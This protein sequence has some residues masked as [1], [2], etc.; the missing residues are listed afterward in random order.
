MKKG[1]EGRG[2]GERF[3][4]PSPYFFGTITRSE[5]LLVGKCHIGKEF[6]SHKIGLKHQHGSLET[7]TY[8]VLSPR[9]YDCVRRSPSCPLFWLFCLGNTNMS[10]LWS[11]KNSLLKKQTNNGKI[12]LKNWTSTGFPHVFLWTNAPTPIIGRK[13]ILFWDW[14]P[15][16][17]WHRHLVSSL[18]ALPPSYRR[19]VVAR[20]IKLGTVW[21]ICPWTC[22]QESF[23]RLSSLRTLHLPNV[24]STLRFTRI[25]VCCGSILSLV[26]TL[27][28]FLLITIHY[29]TPKQ[30][31]IKFN[32]EWNW[33][34]TY[35]WESG[36]CGGIFISDYSVHL[37]QSHR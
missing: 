27:V 34:T 16:S 4:S 5:T 30:R 21:D 36:K 25:D 26:F 29:H 6:S 33:T 7:P 9:K 8:F 10:W 24:D 14:W 28:I 3:L 32:P 37:Q 18:E 11:C 17:P 22:Y 15:H 13:D 20:E 23:Q 1:D 31:E 2:G 35:I 19:L 12:K